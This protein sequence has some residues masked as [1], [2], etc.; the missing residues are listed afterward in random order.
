NLFSAGVDYEQ[1][2]AV[3]DS[4][5]AGKNRVAPD[6][7]NVGVFLQDQFA[8]AARL[9]LTAGVRIE[10]NR[11]DMPAG[12]AQILSSLGS[13][14]LNGS[15]GFGTKVAPKVA[16]TIL[17]RHGESQGAVGATRLSANYGEGIKE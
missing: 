4:G 13:K 9:I 14:N 10:H 2:H 16:V 17:A 12:L 7:T 5:F 15:P 1:E 8:Y 3:F 6:R 11:A